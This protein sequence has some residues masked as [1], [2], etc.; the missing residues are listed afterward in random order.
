MKESSHIRERS[1]HLRKNCEHG[2]GEIRRPDKKSE[3]GKGKEEKETESA[4]ADTSERGGG[5]RGGREKRG[6]G[7]GIDTV[8]YL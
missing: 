8:Y 5:E 7:H 4:L 2:N 3:W 6:K 1:D